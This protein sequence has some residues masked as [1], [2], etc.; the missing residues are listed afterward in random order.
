VIRIPET[1]AAVST[2]NVNEAANHT[3]AAIAA[4]RMTTSLR[5]VSSPAGAPRSGARHHVPT[6]SKPTVR[7]AARSCTARTSGKP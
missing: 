7:A 4:R 1:S 5:P 2:M 3:A 6:A